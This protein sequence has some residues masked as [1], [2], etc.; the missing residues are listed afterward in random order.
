MHP[1]TFPNGPYNGYNLGNTVVHE[2][3]HWMGLLHTF[4]V[5]WLRTAL[6]SVSILSA[7]QPASGCS[8]YHGIHTLRAGFWAWSPCHVTRGADGFCDT[9]PLPRTDDAC[10]R[11]AARS[12][13]TASTTRRRRTSPSSGAP[14]RRPTRARA[15]R[16]TSQR[17]TQ[18]QTSW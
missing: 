8:E 5:R 11:A 7:G 2:V 15:S 3:G 1:W 9:K 14:T 4:E 16:Q 17:S 12:P 18:S 10:C 13:T 6:Q